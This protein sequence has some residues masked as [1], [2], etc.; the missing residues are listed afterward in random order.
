MSIEEK[1]TKLK[2]EMKERFSLFAV[3]LATVATLLGG[4][5]AVSSCA[6]GE[7]AEDKKEEI[8]TSVVFRKMLYQDKTTTE[9]RV[10]LE[11]G[12]EICSDPYKR[13]T[14]CNQKGEFLEVGDT[15]T[16]QGDEISAIRYKDGAGKQVNFGEIGKIKKD[17]TR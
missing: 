5:T 8:K 16:Y 12:D 13:E 2:S 11:N 1:I 15:V 3:K 7:Q 14:T 17:M 9:N 6:K 10:L 4:T